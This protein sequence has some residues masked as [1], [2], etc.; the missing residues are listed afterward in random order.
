[1]ASAVHVVD[2]I[3][4][5]L[6]MDGNG[7]VELADLQRMQDDLGE[8]GLA[9]L[10]TAYGSVDSERRG[11]LDKLQFMQVPR[12]SISGYRSLL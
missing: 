7:A 3:F 12:L 9:I 11:S 8:L 1:M 4:R 5:L 6:D 2:T 10:E